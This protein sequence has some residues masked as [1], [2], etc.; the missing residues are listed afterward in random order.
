MKNTLVLLTAGTLLLSAGS[1]AYAE[2]NKPGN[3]KQEH[4]EKSKKMHQELQERLNLTEDQ[5][6]KE[7]QLKMEAKKSLQPIMQEKRKKFEELQQ[8]QQSK[9]SQEQITAKKDELKKLHEQAN[10]IRKD[11]MQKFEAILTPEQKTKFESYR[12]EMKLKRQ[13]FRKNRK[14]NP[15]KTENL[16]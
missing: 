14:M 1:F 4:C 10:V 11:H 16:N 5:K 9:A 2:Q 12:E 3:F 15:N 13:E 8:L 7:K 6:T